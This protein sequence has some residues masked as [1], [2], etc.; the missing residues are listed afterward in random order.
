[1]LLVHQHT[2]R[3]IADAFRGCAVEK[4][5]LLGSDCSLSHI[6]HCFDLP[7]SEA[8]LHYYTPDPG[9]ADDVIGRWGDRGI[10]FCG[11]IHSHVVD[12]QDLSVNDIAFA[13]ALYTAYQLPILWFGIGIVN[14][15]NVV[16][17]FYAVSE[18]ENQIHVTPAEYI[19]ENELDHWRY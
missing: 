9:I 6:N 13:K 7:A 11:L 8:G 19:I 2:L 18:S 1:M 14:A 4:G 3:K 5:F 12:K 16:F 10:C 17:R 15:G